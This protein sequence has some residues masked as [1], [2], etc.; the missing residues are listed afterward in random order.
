MERKVQRVH[1]ARLGFWGLKSR[2]KENRF[3][4]KC[5]DSDATGRHY[6]ARSTLLGSRAGF[7]ANCRRI[8]PASHCITHWYQKIIG[9][10]RG[11]YRA[12]RRRSCRHRT[13]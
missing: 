13:A 9:P 5:E 11:L 7:L 12:H 2:L 3:F 1:S 4:R 10:G 8:E 6:C